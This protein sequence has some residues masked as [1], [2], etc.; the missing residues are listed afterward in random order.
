MAHKVNSKPLCMMNKAL[1]DLNSE[2][3]PLRSGSLFSY[4]EVHHSLCHRLIHVGFPWKQTLRHIEL[5]CRRLIRPWSWDY[6]DKKEKKQKGAERQVGLWQV[7]CWSQLAWKSSDAVNQGFPSS[8]QRARLPA[9]LWLQCNC[10]R[11]RL[12]PQS[13]WKLGRAFR[14]VLNL[15]WGSWA[16]IP[17]CYQSLDVDFLWKGTWPWANSLQLRQFRKRADSWRLSVGTSPAAGAA[18]PSREACHKFPMA[19]VFAALWAPLALLGGEASG[20]A[21]LTFKIGLWLL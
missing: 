21:R 15:R 8:P 1:H 19:S 20:R 18:S 11:P 7:I 6:Q 10:K 12:N 5:E 16:S 14:V 17:L 9:H 13:V 4:L 2:L 3:F